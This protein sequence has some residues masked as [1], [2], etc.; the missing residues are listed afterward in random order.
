MTYT[1]FG[2]TL[3]LAQSVKEYYYEWTTR[4]TIIIMSLDDRIPAVLLL[5]LTLMILLPLRVCFST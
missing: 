2:G 1:V 4:L 5:L 3:N